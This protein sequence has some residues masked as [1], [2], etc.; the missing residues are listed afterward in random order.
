MEE[1]KKYS[2][3]TPT[4][5]LIF[6]LLILS[7]LLLRWLN[8]EVRPIHHDE[9]LHA[10]YGIYFY[11]WPEEKFYRYDPMLH[12]PFMYNLYPLIYAIFGIT[13]WSIR[14][15]VAFAGTLFMF[16][17]WI[18]R[19]YFSNVSLLGLTAAVALS[20]SMVYW[21]R[22]IHHDEYVLTGMLLMLYGATLAGDKFRAAFVWSGIALQWTIKANVY[23][24]LA[25]IFGYLVYEFVVNFLILGEKDSLVQRMFSQISRN[26]GGFI[27]GFLLGAFIFCYFYSSGFRYSDGILDGLYRKGFSYWLHNHQIERIS[28]PFLFHFYMLSWYEF[29]FIIALL[30]QTYLFY[31]KTN[32]KFRIAGIVSIVAAAIW[33]SVLSRD[34]IPKMPIWAFFKLKDGLD[35]FG[36]IFL[37]THSILITTDHLLKRE[38]RLAFFAYLYLS[39]FFAYSFAG[40]KTPWLSLYPLVTGF[41]YYTL[42]FQDHYEKSP[43]QNFENYSFRKALLFVGSL[44]FLLG[45]CFLLESGMPANWPWLTCGLVL[46]GIALVDYWAKLFGGFNLRSA[47]FVVGALFSLHVSI[48]T[49]FTY[50]GKA[51]ELISQVHTTP[52]YDNV[53]RDIRRQML[54]ADED[55]RPQMLVTGEGVWPTVWYLRSLP[56][57]YDATPEQK[58]DFKWI[59]QDWKDNATDLPEGYELRKLKLRGWWVPDYKEMTFKRY[60]AYAINHQPWKPG[61]GGDPSGFSYVALLSKK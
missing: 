10:M 4:Q 54:L 14:F 1:A 21:S 11:D 6:G 5:W 19:R 57:R 47:L 7:G 55:K 59:M 28:G 61:W 33:G 26:M 41:I 58:K 51:N 37:V 3:F 46:I 23:I 8:L 9:S 53:V 20:P 40:E 42:Y 50:A 36:L 25:L 30:F 18:F 32:Q 24:T 39:T 17:P 52:D 49:N 38:S 35:I 29:P 22:L 60:L 15:P 43:V 27:F 13:D 31:K 16:V 45:F 2:G 12:G 56:L 34:E 44:I 48:M